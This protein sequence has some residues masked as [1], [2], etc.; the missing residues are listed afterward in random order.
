[1]VNFM[2]L[3]FLLFFEVFGLVDISIMVNVIYNGKM[4]NVKDG[5]IEVFG[6]GYFDVVNGNNVFIVGF[7]VIVDWLDM[8]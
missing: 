4:Y 7:F 5:W 6:I 3:V 2:V 8:L 1:M